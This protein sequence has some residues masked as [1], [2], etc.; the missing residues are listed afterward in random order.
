M[1]SSQCTFDLNRELSALETGVRV[2]TV[3]GD[4][5]GGGMY[6]LS[7]IAFLKADTLL[8]SLQ[9]DA[10]ETPAL[11]SG[12]TCLVVKDGTITDR[13]PCRKEVRQDAKAGEVFDFVWPSGGKTVVRVRPA[14][15]EINGAPA[16]YVDAP[17]GENAQCA[18]NRKTNNVFCVSPSF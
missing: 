5:G 3:G 10:E 2:E 7:P 11:P 1:N 12:A 18:V 14:K 9:I 13:E 15:L 4:D 17:Q 8:A 16:S 6:R